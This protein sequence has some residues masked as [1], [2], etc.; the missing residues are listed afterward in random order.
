VTS[1][2]NHHSIPC[3]WAECAGAEGWTNLADAAAFLGISHRTLPLAVD[4]SEI[5][6]QHPLPDSLSVIQQRS[7]QTPAAVNLVQRV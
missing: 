3:Y 6:A 2:R 7:L 5:D 1:L 4:R